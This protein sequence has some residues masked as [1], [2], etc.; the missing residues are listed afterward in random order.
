MRFALLILIVAAVAP[1]S[2]AAA[3]GFAPCPD[4][5]GV[6]CATLQV[7]VDRSNASAGTIDLHVERV[8]ARHATRPPLLSLAGGPGQAATNET[9]ADRELYGPALDSRDLIVFDQR[10]TGRSGALHCSA[11]ERG[12]PPATAL[13]ACAQ[14]L[15]T[16][17][18]SYTTVDSA[19]DIE[20]LRQA[21]GVPRLAIFG[22][23]YGTW[24]AQVYARR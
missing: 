22:V 10:G 8:P 11:I 1:E 14:Q 18:H 13:P 24:T 6:Q 4:K 16:A 3:I 21:L 2:A 23:S 5:A 12:E 20:A 7:P 9:L 19:E 17:A 15:G